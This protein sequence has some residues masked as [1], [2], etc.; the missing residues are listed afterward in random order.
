[1]SLFCKIPFY[2]LLATSFTP[3]FGIIAV[4]KAE[5]I[6][7]KQNPNICTY[8]PMG[9]TE[10]LP[11][12]EE[13]YAYALY[14]LSDDGKKGIYTK[15]KDSIR[16]VNEPFQ[17][18]SKSI[19]TGKEEV[20]LKV[21]STEW[22]QDSSEINSLIIEHSDT[23]EVGGQTEQTNGGKK[24]ISLINKT[25]LEKSEYTTSKPAKKMSFSPKLGKAY[26]LL[27]T[28]EVEI[29][30]L[31][32]GS[33]TISK[34]GCT[35]G[36]EA[37]SG[38]GR[39][40]FKMDFSKKEI[41]TVDLTTGELKKLPWK[42]ENTFLEGIY[43]QKEGDNVSLCVANKGSIHIVDP[44]TSTIKKVDIQEKFDIGRRSS[45]AK[46]RS[47]EGE[48]EENRHEDINKEK[49]G[50]IVCSAKGDKVIFT[51]INPKE[52]STYIWHMDLNTGKKIQ[53]DSCKAGV[54]CSLSLNDNMPGYVLTPS[55][56]S[57]VDKLLY[58]LEDG[59]L[60]DKVTPE[61]YG[62]SKDGKWFYNAS[63]ERLFIHNTETG[64]IRTQEASDLKSSYVRPERDG[65]IQW[66][67]GTDSAHNQ[68]DLNTREIARFRPI[69]PITYRPKFGPTNNKMIFD[70]STG[71]KKGQITSLCVKL[72]VE[73][74]KDLLNCEAP[75]CD[76]NY[77]RQVEEMKKQAKENVKKLNEKALCSLPFQG[78]EKEWDE[79]TPAVG[80]SKIDKTQ[81]ELYLKRFSKPGGFK[82][83][84]HLA[85]LYAALEWETS[86]HE[87]SN[88]LFAPGLILGALQGAFL[89]SPLLYEH[90]VAEFPEVAK[91]DYVIKS[92]EAS[93]AC[94]TPKEKKS[95]EEKAAPYLEEQMK[96]AKKPTL[97]EN[98]AALTALS[99][100][101]SDLPEAKKA[102]M[103]EKMTDSLRDSALTRGSFQHIFSSKINYLISDALNPLFGKK[104]AEFTDVG[105]QV[106]NVED[107]HL[108]V[109]PYV[110]GSKPTKFENKELTRNEW[111]FYSGNLET[112][113]APQNAAVGQKMVDKEVKWRHGDTQYSAKLTGI[114][115]RRNAIPMGAKSPDYVGM[116]KDNVLTEVHL[117]G[118]SDK[119]NGLNAFHELLSYYKSAGL[120]FDEEKWEKIPDLPL[121]IK[122][123]IESNKMDI[124]MKHAHSDGDDK[125]LFLMDIETWY[126]KGTYE[127]PTG[128]KEEVYLVW[129]NGHKH[130]TVKIP[131]ANF[132]EWIRTREKKG[133]TQLAF[134]NASCW[135]A[136]KAVHELIEA[137]SPL[138]LDIASTTGNYFFQNQANG[139]E[140]YLLSGL[141][142]GKT[143]DEI[144]KDMKKNE[145]YAKGS[146]SQ[147]L[148]PDDPKYKVAVQDK[149]A[150]PMRMKIDVFTEKDGIKIPYELPTSH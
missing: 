96:N 49:V 35:Y 23:R 86:Y 55:S 56:Q 77:A 82:P 147:F 81:M 43:G 7:K 33:K 13:G 85:T 53:L 79:I 40:L 45:F 3:A 48:V 118:A 100:L 2:L 17:I 61:K 12:I 117:I 112:I 42:Y 148:F 18:I 92:N 137:N 89:A 19:E 139:A 93:N 9:K 130:E 64:E 25:T 34:P 59:E 143:Y 110:V 74:E 39:Y 1:M 67:N 84:E 102:E 29:L 51:T 142:A 91:L 47:S 6:R 105:Y 125:N 72:N 99:S 141:R 108:P 120:K 129:P 88:E 111:G 62:F 32:T 8:F 103:H 37:L 150:T 87:N 136:Q 104:Q 126:L 65:K 24:R 41:C 123:M 50:R 135:S 144:R 63:A 121:F 101:I 127:Y 46:E 66:G 27:N 31:K 140:R 138:L 80:S 133:G 68:L 90:L 134:V 58:R 78:N 131:N 38:N 145:H 95:I 21:N 146:D 70:T 128:E 30:D 106:G 124:M 73:V 54:T 107:N 28:N 75:N 115:E 122:D 60:I 98:W 116:W 83:K 71:P 22:V 16:A 20:L 109:T 113:L 149:M 4:E 119:K 11:E 69:D 94:V 57:S 76:M 97:L 114:A 44:T 132:G 15:R 10:W 52:E 14:H 5:K 36:T 26:F